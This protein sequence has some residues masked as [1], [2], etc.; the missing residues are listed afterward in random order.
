MKKIGQVVVAATVAMIPL[1]A[2]AQSLTEE[3]ARAAI[4]PW[5]ALFN[6][7]VQGDMRTLQEQVPEAKTSEWWAQM[8]LVFDLSAVRS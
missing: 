1:L 5:Y 7:P 4:A 2:S 3:Q 8:E 6:Q